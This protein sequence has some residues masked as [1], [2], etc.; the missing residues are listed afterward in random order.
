MAE[1][2]KDTSN[3]GGVLVK[4]A[5]QDSED[6]SKSLINLSSGKAGSKNAIVG[7]IKRTSGLEAPVMQLIGHD[8]E[9][10]SCE[11]DHSGE[12]IASA[13]FD[14]QILLWNTYGEVKNYGVLKGHTN[15]VM[16]IHWSRDSNQIFSCSA[17]KTVGIFDIK[18][19]TRTRRWR[20]HSGIVNSCQVARRG[21]E[22]VVSG[23]DDCT[24][25]IW[26]NRTKEAVSTF[27]N[28]YQVTSVCFS[29]A[30]DMI[31]SAGLDND[32][33][34]WDVRKNQLAYTMKGHMDTIAGM[35]L[36]P[37]GNNLLTNSMDNTVRIWD[38]KP[39]AA[40]DRCLK[41]FEGAPHG[42]EKNL[43]KPCWATDGSQIACGSADRSVVIWDVDTRKILYKL[44]GHKGCVNDVDWHPK[45][46]IIM[47]AK[48]SPIKRTVQMDFPPTIDDKEVFRLSIA[49]QSSTTTTSA[50][51]SSQRL[52]VA[53]GSNEDNAQM[54]NCL[55]NLTTASSLSTSSRYLFSGHSTSQNL[56][57]RVLGRFY[58]SLSP[59]IS[60]KSHQKSLSDPFI[61]TSEMPPFSLADQ[62][63]D[64]APN[65]IDPS[66]MSVKLATESCIASDWL[67][68]FE[69]T[70]FAFSRSWKR[71]LFV[72]I[73]HIV[74][75][76]TSSKPTTPAKEH[77]VL[78]DDTFV[79][80]TEEFKKGFNIELRKPNCKWF[81]RCESVEQM[82]CW[83]ETMKKI[84]AC[85]KIG[86][87]GLLTESILA[88]ITLTD[89]YRILV[90]VQ[91]VAAQRDG[92]N[93]RQSFP[94]SLTYSSKI[95]QG[96]QSL[97]DIPNWEYILPPQLPPP[98]SRPPPVP[99]SHI[100]NHHNNNNK[101]TN[102]F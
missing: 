18:T 61:A 92:Q 55:P 99:S 54:S 93:N 72:L 10:F 76:F 102:Y 28:E 32:V 56:R 80:V 50:S 73:D 89:N 3:G 84:V 52:S 29:D 42:F 81:I 51:T 38:I 22:L 5:K 40:A 27:E 15:A 98:T 44:P 70:T 90:P 39:F 48:D 62:G 30:G 25:K 41:I 46:P 49:S 17:D 33:K 43:I 91:L 82:R 85:I 37:D 58:P 24:V 68:K 34:V 63:T 35:S 26:D 88:S 77:F 4:R 8:G 71:R 53:S 9:I 16:E 57:N 12:Y 65:R 67:Q 31:Y 66:H 74:Y 7:T 45:E 19:G 2:R 96:Q 101:A 14:R 20:G 95:S 97:T 78:T 100:S 79:F 11:F 83:L 36:S 64:I 47:S 6:T 86:Y 94:V 59:S 75:N 69:H 87:D 21:A 1:K 60:N 13:G 23:S